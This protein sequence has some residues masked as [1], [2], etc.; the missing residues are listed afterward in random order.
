MAELDHIRIEVRFYSFFKD[1]TDCAGTSESVRSGSTLG[2]LVNHLIRRFPKLDP[3]QKSML[4]AVGVE[5]QDRTYVLRD[6]DEVSFFP[7]VQGG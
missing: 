7:P 2:E 1:L 5:Y 6:G 3:M 4:L